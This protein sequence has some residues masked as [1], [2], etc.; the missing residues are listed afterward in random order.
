MNKYDPTTQQTRTTDNAFFLPVVLTKTRRL[1]DKGQGLELKDKNQGLFTLP[2]F[3]TQQTHFHK[4][5]KRTDIVW[6]VCVNVISLCV[7]YADTPASH[8]HNVI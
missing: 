2:A 4:S 3:I 8:Y 7:A 6:N 5:F 1:K